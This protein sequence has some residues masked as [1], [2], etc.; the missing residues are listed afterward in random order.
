MLDK[1]Y[2]FDLDA[3]NFES[4]NTKLQLEVIFA[5]FQKKL[6]A[7]FFTL[8]ARFLLARPTPPPW[9]I[10]LSLLSKGKLSFPL[11]IISR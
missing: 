9:S 5:I 4:L 8:L 3:I 7:R 2:C 1:V 11:P 10:E 6:L